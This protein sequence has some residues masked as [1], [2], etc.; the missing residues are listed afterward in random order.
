MATRLFHAIGR[1]DVNVDPRYSTNAARLKNVH[2]VDAIVS[3]FIG[4][5][6]LAENLRVFQDA[7]VT[8]GPICDAAQLLTD[9]YVIARESLIDVEDPELGYMPMH[10]VVPRLSATPGA[11]RRPAPRKGQHTA[12]C[13]TEL[14]GDVDLRLLFDQ[15]VIFA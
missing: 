5:R 8:V 11:L 10:N 13:L 14:L 4:A 6:T 3:D 12:Q 7:E 1:D 9:H 2:E 15:G